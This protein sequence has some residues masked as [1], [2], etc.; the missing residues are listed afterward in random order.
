MAGTRSIAHSAARSRRSFASAAGLLALTS[1]LAIG[2]SRDA[3]ARKEGKDRK[4]DRPAAAQGSPAPAEQA[5]ADASMPTAK[6][7]KSMA[8]E[9]II[10]ALGVN[11]SDSAEQTLE[12]IVVGAIPFGAH[13]RQATQFALAKLVLNPSPRAK[14]FLVSV[15]AGPEIAPRPMGQQ[16]YSGAQVRD[17]AARVVSMAAP[18]DLRA[19]LAKAYDRP[20]VSPAAR[21]MIEEILSAPAAVNVPA[22]LDLL[23]SPIASEPFKQRLQFVLMQENAAAVKQALKLEASAPPAAAAG[24]FAG[25]GFGASRAAAPASLLGNMAKAFAGGTRAGG[26]GG[27]SSPAF[28]QNSLRLAAGG[29]ASGMTVP[30]SPTVMMLRLAER[31]LSSQPVD[32][33]AIAKK[34][35]TPVFAK[36]LDK[37]IHSDQSDG[38]PLVAALASLPINPARSELKKLLHRRWDEGPAAFGKTSDEKAGFVLNAPPGSGTGRGR[39][40]GADAAA[41]RHPFRAKLGAGKEPE[42][43]HIIEFGVDWLDPGALVVLK[44]IQPGYE[45]RPKP[46]T[47]NR[48]TTGTGKSY[49]SGTKLSPA[50]ERRAEERA[51]KLAE[52][53]KLAEA[54]YE[55]REAVEKFVR[56]W[57]DRFGAAAQPS[58]DADSSGAASAET[59]EKETVAGSETEDKKGLKG[60]GLKITSKGGPVPNP[61]VPMPIALHAGGK[62]AK[63]FHVR[64]PEDLPSELGSIVSDP[65]VIHY[66]R[67]EGDGEFGKTLTHYTSGIKTRKL[68]EIPNGKWV[69]AVQKDDATHRI[70]SMDILVTRP[71]AEDEGE[72]RPKVEP[73]VVEIMIVEIGTLEPAS[74]APA[75]KK[76]ARET[77]G[78]T[79]SRR[80]RAGS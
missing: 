36:L 74:A 76:T 48:W 13:A 32:A 73:L 8:L 37:E 23:N 67:L 66:V 20:D 11:G 27:S 15:L 7:S 17:D 62:I 63:E 21:P 78:V 52:K 61:S 57:A 35:W 34:F 47:T 50:A 72:T 75:S 70:R 6:L 79:R 18:S 68:W 56:Q 5:A 30:Q 22:Q 46:K 43:K 59:S 1:L 25:G 40:K 69:D 64:W 77:T 33:V 39:R 19:A 9:M 80:L 45:N 10:T 26:A 31:M 3:L 16:A 29:P 4:R 49:S 14:A 53:E 2:F 54:K 51:A 60:D 44:T 41:D 24:P 42:P 71:D 12:K 28:P 65:L 55:W 38:A 58:S